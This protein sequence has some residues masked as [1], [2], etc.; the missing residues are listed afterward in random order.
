M[1][2]MY[3]PEIQFNDNLKFSNDLNLVSVGVLGNTENGVWGREIYANS[4]TNKNEGK[5]NAGL[6]PRF[7]NPIDYEYNITKNTNFTDKR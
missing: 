3:S 4:N 1:M 7:I 6:H 2:Q 5:S